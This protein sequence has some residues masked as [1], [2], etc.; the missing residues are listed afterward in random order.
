MDI[1]TS[2]SYCQKECF[3]LNLKSLLPPTTTRVHLNTN[4][5]INNEIRR[6]TKKN[7]DAYKEKSDSEKT[8]R[9]RELDRE[10]DIERTLEA[11]AA[12]L[13]LLSTFLGFFV[14]KRWFTLSGIVGLFLMQHA[15]QGWCPPLPIL[16][17]FGVRTSTEIQDEK[18][19]LRK[20]RGDFNLPK[21]KFL[22]E[23]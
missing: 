10:W 21:Q 5:I 16:R 19:A 3:V 23:R 9:L 15:L 4:P 2:I 7:I 22:Y 1:I 12:G 17:R 18:L 11:N 8:A 13:V 6:R 14:H 20:L